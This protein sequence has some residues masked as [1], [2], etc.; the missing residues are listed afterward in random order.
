MSPDTGLCIHTVNT[1]VY[2]LSSSDKAVDGN[3]ILSMGFAMVTLAFTPMFV[4]LYL[5]LVKLWR[6]KG[7]QH[8]Y[9]DVRM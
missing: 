5:T 9:V 7:L 2:R 3:V 8:A 1:A 4:Q 6:E